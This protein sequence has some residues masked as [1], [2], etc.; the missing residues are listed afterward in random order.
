MQPLLQ[1]NYT[2]TN[3]SS[4][5]GKEAEPL[6]YDDVSWISGTFCIGGIIGTPLYGYLANAVGRKNTTLLSAIPFGI[7]YAL[8]LMATNPVT[9][10]A[11]RLI[12]GLGGGGISVV[13][14]M[15]IGETAE[16]NNRGVLGSYFNLFICIGILSSYIVGSYTSYLIL[17]LYCLFFPILFVVLWFWLPESPSYCVLNNR[18][19]EALKA[20]LK[21]RG[22]HRE[23]IEAE[24]SDLTTSIKDKSLSEKEKM[25]FKQMISEPE[26][27][28]GFIIGGTLMTIQQMSGISPILNYTVVIFEASGSEMS[29]NLAAITVGILQVFGAIV[30]TLL[31]DRA[32]RKLLLIISSVGMALSLAGMASFFHLKSIDYDPAF[33]RSIGWLPVTCMATFVV[34]YGLGFGPVPYVIIGEIFKTEARSAATS[35]STFLIWAEAFILLKFYS[36]LNDLIG[37]DSCFGLFSFCCV[38]G[39]L[40]TYFYIPETKGKSLEMILWE[41]GGKKP[42]HHFEENNPIPL[43]S[44]EGKRHNNYQDDPTEETV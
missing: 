4:P 19:E 8:I 15:Y 24:L 33:M 14:P 37:T 25:S 17:G 31:M 28:K 41:L 43:V 22:N 3:E 36:K 39:A 13:A 6:T 26:T 40:F 27:R 30:A 34:V 10:F 42:V 5:L 38:L 23:L 12:A 32:G 35:F 7:A 44:S 20:L 16:V 9:I 29:P 18:N 2:N 11:A 1:S 21:L